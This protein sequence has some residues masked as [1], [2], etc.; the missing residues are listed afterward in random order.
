MIPKEIAII[1]MPREQFEQANHVLSYFGESTRPLREKISAR[2]K[3]KKY[4]RACTFT[5]ER[6]TETT[7]I[8]SAVIC[9]NNARKSMPDANAGEIAYDAALRLAGK[10]TRR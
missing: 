6:A 3:G 2:I 4:G 7:V 1:T 5:G 8:T 9:Y 10:K